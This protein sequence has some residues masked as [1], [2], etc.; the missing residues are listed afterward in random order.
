MTIDNL[1]KILAE[2]NNNLRTCKDNK[3]RSR[4]ASQ[5]KSKDVPSK[6]DTM[7]K[8]E[9][10]AE[11]SHPQ[12]Y[13]TPQI[14]AM[15]PPVITSNLSCASP[16]RANSAVHK[17]PLDLSEAQSYCRGENNRESS[18][19]SPARLFQRSVS[20]TGGYQ[21]PSESARYQGSPVES[22][23]DLNKVA[24]DRLREYTRV[25]ERGLDRG[26]ST[27]YSAGGYSGAENF[28]RNCQDIKNLRYQ[29]PRN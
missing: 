23:R 4:N 17:N 12:S 3:S 26:Q 9:V 2:K 24:S 16:E 29:R 27:R 21:T 7:T 14:K 8:M 10:E 13:G 28:A 1:W 25:L 20:R 5:N 15:T 11:L 18:S 19:R 22:Q 6:K